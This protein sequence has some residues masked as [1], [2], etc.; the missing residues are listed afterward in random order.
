M[1]L[2]PIPPRAGGACADRLALV[3][4]DV[5]QRI[6]GPDAAR[7]PLAPGLRASLG[8]AGG[9]TDCDQILAALGARQSQIVQGAAGIAG[10]AL[11]PLVGRQQRDEALLAATAIGAELAGVP[12]GVRAADSAVDDLARQACASGWANATR[13]QVDLIY[14]RA[15]ARGIP[16]ARYMTLS[17]VCAAIVQD[18]ADDA[19]EDAAVLATS[20][21]PYDGPSY[22]PTIYGTGQARTDG[23]WGQR[24]AYSNNDNGAYLARYDPLAPALAETVAASAALTAIDAEAEALDNVSQ[25]LLRQSQAAAAQAAQARTRSQ[26]VQADISAS[27]QQQQRIGNG[28]LPYGGTRGLGGW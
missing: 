4:P 15:L 23:V 22:A 3:Y 6:Y 14:D 20:A 18:V 8:I 1:S 17:Q 10:S 16:G 9:G 2:T 12:P 24:A 25:Q 13:D 28:A 11:G 5:W 26:L 7:D 21:S 27:Q 19:A